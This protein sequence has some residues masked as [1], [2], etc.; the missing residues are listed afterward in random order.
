MQTCQ[1]EK[2]KPASQTA[3]FEF[4]EDAYR[5]VNDR[6]VLVSVTELQVC[7]MFKKCPRFYGV[8]THFR[9][10]QEFSIAAGWAYSGK[11][12]SCVGN[13]I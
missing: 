12:F 2:Y 13:L 9:R 6:R 10:L 3:E 8:T 4:I 5:N 11:Y 1:T 7:K